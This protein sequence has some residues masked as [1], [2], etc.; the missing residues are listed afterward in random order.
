MRYRPGLPLVLRDVSFE[1]PK[2]GEKVAI[3]GRTGSGKSSL[4]NT[5]LQMRPLAGGI[6]E[7]GGRDV[8]ELPLAQLRGA[9]SMI[10]Q[11]PMLFG[12]GHTLEGCDA[13]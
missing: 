6:I 2:A 10:P 9:V 7:M 3:C 13:V 1:V 8:T 5:I 4:I 11:D 12:K